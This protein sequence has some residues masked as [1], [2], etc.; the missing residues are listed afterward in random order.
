MAAL[1]PPTALRGDV[2]QLPGERGIPQQ[3]AGW[4]VVFYLSSSDSL[5]VLKCILFS[6][7][8]LSLGTRD[9]GAGEGAEK[10]RSLGRGSQRGTFPPRR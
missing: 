3:G 6:V 5:R 8:S 4:G 2:P 9:G 1:L 10:P 7:E